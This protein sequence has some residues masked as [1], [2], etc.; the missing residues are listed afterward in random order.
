MKE[1]ITKLEKENI[2]LKIEMSELILELKHLQNELKKNK[3]LA[4][5]DFLTRLANRSSF[6]RSLE[7]MLKDYKEM[8]YPFGL[9][10]IDL[11]NF[12]SINDNYSHNHGDLVLKEVSKA[13]ILANRANSVIGRLGGEE[14]GI[15]VPGANENI[16]NIISERVRIAIEE[17]EV[18]DITVNV[19]ASIGF[20]LPSTEDSLESIIQNADKAMYFSKN[21]G[22]NQITN[23]KDII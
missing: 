22:K 7:D 9:I 14:F 11:D 18:P 1:T 13:L 23:F 5:F 21:N 16:L 8:N 19:T 10:Y 3:K 20:Y 4:N 17:I 2:E 15:A 6:T 12:K